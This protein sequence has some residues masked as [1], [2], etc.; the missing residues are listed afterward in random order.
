M[1]VGGN[2]TALAR[3]QVYSGRGLVGDVWRWVQSLEVRERLWGKQGGVR[4][5]EKVSQGGAKWEN[6]AGVFVLKESTFC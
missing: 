6:K 3:R 2:V 1:L 5:P 4:A